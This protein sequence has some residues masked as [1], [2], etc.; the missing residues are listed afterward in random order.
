MDFINVYLL[1]WIFSILGWILEMIYCAIDDKKIVNRGFLIGPYCPI[2]GF[3]ALVMLLLTPFKDSAIITFILALLLCS[4]LEYFTSYLM[5]KVFKVRWWDYSHESFNI[6]GRICLKNAIAFGALGV[7]FNKFL[8]P[9]FNDFI[10][11]L[12]VDTKNII[13]IVILVITIIDILVSL[14]VM[15][16]IKDII[17]KNE[18]DFKKI[19]ATENINKLFKI[20]LKNIDWKEHR[21]I[22]TYHLLE[23]KINNKSNYLILIIFVVIGLIIGSLLSFVFHLGSFKVIIPLVVSITLLLAIM[24]MKVKK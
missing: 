8:E 4:V 11:L 7:L 24:V 15:N 13:A 12:S 18:K 1:F 14:K 10:N 3:G 6:N 9:Y 5:E 22:N 20:K 17:K 21:L 16:S 23:R 2:Y 19:D